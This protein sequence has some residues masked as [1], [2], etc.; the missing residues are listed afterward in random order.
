MSI[1]GLIFDFGGVL[2]NMR[3]D[4]SLELERAHGL[5]ERAIVE[6]LY[7]N[8]AWRQIEVGEGDREAW[9]RDAHVQLESLAGRALPPLHQHWRER[10]HAIVP[11]IELVRALRPPYRTAVLSNA[12]VTL[13]ERLRAN[14]LWELFDDVVCSAEVRLAKP[15]PRIYALAAERLGLAAAEC[16]FI[17]DLESNVEAARAT[18]MHGV[19]F[20]VDRG[21]DLAAQLAE[22]GVTPRREQDRRVPEEV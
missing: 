22:L 16:V 9:L 18:G 12:D 6:T 5:R 7:G 21:D 19:H 11:N 8:G 1:R 10:Q 17:D 20:R 13:P 2:W 14:G 4:V 15:E 3:W